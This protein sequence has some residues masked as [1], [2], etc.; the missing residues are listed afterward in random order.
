MFLFLKNIFI[1]RM[2]CIFAKYNKSKY[3]AGGTKNTHEKIENLI[4]HV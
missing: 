4:I 3:H 2:P 1:A